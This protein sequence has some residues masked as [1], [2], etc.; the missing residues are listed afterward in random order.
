VDRPQGR[1][2]AGVERIH[3]CRERIRPGLAGVAGQQRDAVRRAVDNPVIVLQHG[4][5]VRV[6]GQRAGLHQLDPDGDGLAMA[7]LDAADLGGDAVGGVGHW[8]PFRSVV[9]CLRRGVVREGPFGR[10]AGEAERALVGDPGLAGATE[11]AQRLRAGGVEQVVARQRAGQ[12]IEL[13]QCH[14]R[15]GDLAQ[16][17][18]PVQADHWGGQQGVQRVIE[19]Q[20]LRPIGSLPGLRLGVAGHDRCLQLVATRA[21]SSRS[22]RWSASGTW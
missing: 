6:L 3:S 17:D 18:R 15:A 21:A 8:C 5:Y 2:L 12:G 7:L 1:P 11:I 22:V 16:R 10:V 9:G 4:H 13:G 20:D 14:G 19:Q